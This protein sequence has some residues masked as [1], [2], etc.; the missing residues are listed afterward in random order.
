[1]YLNIMIEAILEYKNLK[2][3]LT[4][5]HGCEETPDEVMWNDMIF[6]EL[7]EMEKSFP[8]EIARLV[9]FNLI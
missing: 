9:K 8:P 7:C 1:M 4:P 3:K 2:Q 6:A 5:N